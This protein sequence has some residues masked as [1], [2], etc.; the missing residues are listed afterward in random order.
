[1]SLLFGALWWLTV[2]CWAGRVGA[3]WRF[4]RNPDHA[5]PVFI[6][7]YFL[8]F[9]LALLL[10]DLVMLAIFLPARGW[11]SMIPVLAV[12]AAIGAATGLVHGAAEY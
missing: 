9:A 1:M 8:H 6:S 12:S 5:S 2:H 4:R 7:R 3:G 11:H 10:I